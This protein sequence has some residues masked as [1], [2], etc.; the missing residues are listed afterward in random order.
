VDRNFQNPYFFDFRFAFFADRTLDFF[1]VYTEPTMERSPAGSNLVFAEG[2]PFL[3]LVQWIKTHSFIGHSDG[4]PTQ[5]S[6]TP[7][8]V[9][10]AER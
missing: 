8:S 6:T 4:G 5:S 7:L 10:T 3:P 1:A 2:P 9:R